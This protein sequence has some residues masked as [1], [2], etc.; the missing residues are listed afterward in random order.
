MLFEYIW[1]DKSGNLRSKTK[2][3]KNNFIVSNLSDIPIWNY[4]GSSTGQASGESSEVLLKPVYMCSDPF[5]TSSDRLVL[6]ETLNADFTPH[7][8]NN[9]AKLGSLS[10]LINIHKPVFGF[11][12]EFFVLPSDSNYEYEEAFKHRVQGDF[13]C[14]VGGNNVNIRSFA[15]EAMKMCLKAG[16]NITGMNAEVAPNQWEFQVCSEGLEACD[17]LYILRYILNI[18]GEKYNYKIDLE[19][20]PFSNKW[21]G[22]GCHT[23]FSTLA[24]RTDTNRGYDNIMEFIYKLEYKHTEFMK[25]YGENNDKRMTGDCE[26]ASFDNFSYGVGDRTAS[27][28]IPNSVKDNNT[29]YLEDRRPG[30]NIDPYVIAYLL[31]KNLE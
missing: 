5:R 3:L 11:E 25:H 30:S 16:L 23:N 2:V 18:V 6:C 12:Q 26:T 19:P 17:Q 4:D 22:S 14:G 1:T 13:Y 27:I 15:E 7:I 28:R 31:I 24:M 20:K 29:G 9:R 10:D 8:T 21:N